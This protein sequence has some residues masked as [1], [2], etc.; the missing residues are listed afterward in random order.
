[1]RSMVGAAA[2]TDRARRRLA[3]LL[4]LLC[5]AALTPGDAPAQEAAR[6]ETSDS[7]RIPGVS[8]EELSRRAQEE[9]D[10]GPSHAETALRFFRAG[11]DL[12]PQWADGWWHIG[13]IDFN[14]DRFAEAREALARLVALVPDSGPGW[15][16]LGVCDHRLG[17]YDLALSELVSGRRLGV[18]PSDSLGQESA[19]SLAL[20]LVRGGHSAA[21]GKELARLL[22]ANRD[23]PELILACG[24][25]GL[26]MKLLPGEIPDTEKDLVQRVGRA[27]AASLAWRSDEARALLDDA[28]ARYPKARGVHFLYGRVLLMDASPGAG[29][30]FRR[31]AA[32]FPDHADALV[33]VALDALEHDRAADAVAPART[34][35]RLAPEAVWSHYALGRALVATGATSDGVAELERANAIKASEPDVLLA[36][37]QAYARAGRTREVERVRAELQNVSAHRE[38]HLLR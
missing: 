23:D 32:L 37:A 36:L 19:R 1:M 29:E 38:A 20:L 9:W 12:N 24:L 16:L 25:Y 3:A 35:V 10:A 7:P 21:A 18:S 8:F 28:L 27:T 26:Q 14:L 17:H 31:E 5:C 13:L 33:E 22:G 30:W 2:P 34:A 6:A 4:G 11:V 15:S